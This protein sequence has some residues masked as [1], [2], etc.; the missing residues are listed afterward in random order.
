MERTYVFNQ[1]G[2]TGANNGLLASILPSLQS[3]GIDTGYLMGLM[4]GNG[5]GGF[6]GNNGGFQDIIALIV[7]AAIFRN[8]DYVGG[9][10]ISL[11][12]AIP[13]G[14]TATLPIL[15]GTNGDTRPLMAYNNEPVTVANLAGTGI[16]EIHYNKYTNELYLVNGGYRP[17]T[18]PAPTVETAS[19]RSK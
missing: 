5:N 2:G 7:I 13:A 11:R 9:F 17:T 8:R 3:R 14:T 19:L 12:Q 18:A 1:D 6:F 4:G 15:I 16:Y 10:Y